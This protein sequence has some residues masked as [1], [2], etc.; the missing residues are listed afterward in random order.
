MTRPIAGD[1]RERTTMLPVRWLAPAASSLLVMSAVAWLG[2]LLVAADM[3]SMPG[4]MGIGFG[5]FVAVWTLMMAAMMLPSVAPVASVSTRRLNDHVGSRLAA[6]SCGYL[7]VWAAV[8]LPA[9]GLACLADE[10]V[11]DHPGAAAMLASAIFA[12]CGIY[13]LGSVKV[14]CLAH[15][16][17]PAPPRLEVGWRPRSARDLRVGARHG[18]CCVGCCWGLM[19]LMLVFGLMNVWAMVAVTA[20]VMVEKTSTRGQ[21]FRRIL[22]AVALALAVLVLVLPGL[23]PGL[24]QSD[25]FGHE[26]H[27][28][29]R[30][31][32]QVKTASVVAQMIA[33]RSSCRNNPT[34]VHREHKVVLANSQAVVRVLEHGVAD[35]EQWGLRVR[36]APRDAENLRFAARL[37]AATSTVSVQGF[38]ALPERVRARVAPSI[39]AA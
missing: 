38:P 20:V 23:A 3:G 1:A 24:H 27:A 36:R 25:A 34:R 35:S 39:P 2:V 10:V 19:T 18:V 21:T 30:R 29:A 37:S 15:C 12:A 16:P 14:R 5:A 17:A 11:A 26:R 7:L 28:H 33:S 13:Q 22:G 6:L 31:H 32:Q 4:T 8:A 9:Y